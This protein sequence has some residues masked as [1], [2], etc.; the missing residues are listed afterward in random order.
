MPESANRHITCIAISLS[1]DNQIHQKWCT[2]YVCGDER[3]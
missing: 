3:A 1:F 2:Y